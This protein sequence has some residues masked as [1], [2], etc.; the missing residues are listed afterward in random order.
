MQNFVWIQNL[1]NI[2]KKMILIF[3]KKTKE[4]KYKK[5]KTERKPETKKNQE[6]NEESVSKTKKTTHMMLTGR[7]PNMP[8]ARAGRMRPAT[9][10]I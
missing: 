7:G 5:D 9:G 2:F 10:G 3:Q 6:K 4:T 8:P 1:F